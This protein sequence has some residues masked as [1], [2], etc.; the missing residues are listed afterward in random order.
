MDLDI[1]RPD[2]LHSEV[3]SVAEGNEDDDDFVGDE[4]DDDNWMRTTKEEDEAYAQQLENVKRDF[5][6]DVDMFDTTMVAEYA[7]EIFQ[8]MEKLE[9]ATMPNPRY[10]D[11]QSEIE[12]CVE[13]VRGIAKS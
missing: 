1:R 5:F 2:T 12:W 8:H 3:S 10:M 7:E 4:E 11:F 6:D 13:P 9:V